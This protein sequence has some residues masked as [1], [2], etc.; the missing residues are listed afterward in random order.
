[1]TRNVAGLVV[2][3][4]NRILLVR[5][6]LS[7]T[8]SIPK[9]EII[10]SETVLETAIRETLEE[11][12]LHIPE[13]YIDKRHYIASCRV[14]GYIR[15]LFYHK[16]FLPDSFDVN[17][18]TSNNEEIEYADFYNFGTAINIIQVSQ[19]AVLWDGSMQI[20]RRITDIMTKVGWLTCNRH[21]YS[22]LLIYD[23]TEKCKQESAWNEVTMW[24][25][26]LITDSKG[27][28]VSRPLKKFF[29]Y[30][31]L[32]PECRPSDKNFL[33][34]DKIDGFMGIM[35]W[36]DDMPY[37]A[38]RDSFV[39]IPAIRGTSILYTK[40]ANDI[41]KLNRSYSYI[42]EIVYPNNSL[43]LD[44]GTTE[45]LFLID[46]F[47]KRGISVMPH[48]GDM[49]FSVIRQCENKFELIHYMEENK[50]GKEGYVIKYNSG[51]RLKIK[52][53]WFKKKY[54][55]KHERKI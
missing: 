6:R 29:E 18:E 25:R 33:V 47:D 5:Q 42:F 51:E 48:I 12:G 31:Q 40:Y 37:I 26:G 22:D 7:H 35:Y 15:K 27:N 39:S 45:D 41:D 20:D 28:I 17:I 34:S 52:F 50:E 1:M 38:T 24:C 54:I 36:I 14:C 8:Y 43:V 21:P 2:Y 10:G 49:P 23:Y 53:P 19:L 16:A 46:V 30:H 55:G 32:Y 9:G 3:H 11:T 44:Y 13:M 4:K